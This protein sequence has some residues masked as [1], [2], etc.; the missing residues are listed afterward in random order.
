MSDKYKLRK[1]DDNHQMD[2]CITKHGHTML[3]I[4]VLKDLKRISDLEA[5]V[6][7]L[8]DKDTDNILHIQDIEARLNESEQHVTELQ[9]LEDKLINNFKDVI[10]L[11]QDAQAWFY[12][13][14]GIGA[15]GV[16]LL[17]RIL[18]INEGIDNLLNP[19]INKDK[20]ND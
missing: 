16:N 1:C 15:A 20:D 9:A 18:D 19:P 11:L 5:Q 14:P 6:K 8:D 13:Q 4:D 3:A 12:H 10:N 7:I 17:N 2:F